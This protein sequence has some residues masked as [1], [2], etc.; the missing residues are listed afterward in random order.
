[1]AYDKPNIK[2]I[3]GPVGD[4]QRPIKERDTKCLV[5]RNHHQM[6]QFLSKMTH[7]PDMLPHFKY[8]RAS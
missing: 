2:I 7:N 4:V 8:Q 3:L 5:A 1:L 6:E